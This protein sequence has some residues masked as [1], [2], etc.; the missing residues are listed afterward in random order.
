MLLA[1]L[2]MNFAKI[3]KYV[4]ITF[5]EILRVPKIVM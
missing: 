1:I 3:S 5:K 2:F 4:I